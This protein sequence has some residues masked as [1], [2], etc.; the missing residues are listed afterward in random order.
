MEALE[1]TGGKQ[2]HAKEL[3]IKLARMHDHNRIL[4]ESGKI[5]QWL[6]FR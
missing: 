4:I 5:Q 3:G 2:C 1:M 6:N